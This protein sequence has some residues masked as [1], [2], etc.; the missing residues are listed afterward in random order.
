MANLTVILLMTL[1][2]ERPVG[3]IT[4]TIEAIYFDRFANKMIR[5][6]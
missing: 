4:A 5:N 2:S 1:F 6:E 3:S